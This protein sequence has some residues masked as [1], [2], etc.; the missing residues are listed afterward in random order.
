V[1]VVDA[2]TDVITELTASGID[3][4]V[5]GF[6]ATLGLNIEN[7]TLSGGAAINGFGNGA[8]N[9]IQGN[10]G[11]N[12]LSGDLG[13]DK[14]DGGDGSDSLS[15]G[16]GADSLSGGAGND[17][18]TGGAGI[19]TLAGGAG[20]DVYYA[21]TV[22]D[23][24]SELVGGGTDTEV[25]S[26]SAI[27][28]LNIENLTL[29]GGSG[30]SGTG[31]AGNNLITGNTGANTLNGGLGQDTLAGGAGA[32]VLYGGAGSDA[33]RLDALPATGVDKVKDFVVID[34]TIQLENSVFTVFGVNTVGAISGSAFQANTTGLAVD[35][36]DRIVYET[37]TGK[38][39]YD[40]DGNG[41]KAAV[42]I[43]ELS[44]GLSLG[45]ADFVLV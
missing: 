3:T 12:V 15:G 38:L 14:L 34:D 44:A 21:D 17:S 1:Y 19:D 11:N 31:N 22:S 40:T 45:Q 13:N 37:D 26:F 29:S 4:E 36:T 9:I 30:L 8:N 27:L 20:N 43:A 33:F 39:F 35:G 6:S 16:D 25:A 42:L 41:S 18:L 10:A 2:V 5:A 28:G 32:D 7:L 23:I 24:L